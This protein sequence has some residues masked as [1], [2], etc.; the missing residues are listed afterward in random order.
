MNTDQSLT[1][2][3]SFIYHHLTE[4]FTL[5]DLAQASHMSLSTLRRLFLKTFAKSPASII[6]Q[7]RMELAFKSIQDHQNSILEIAISAGYDDHAAF[8]RAFKS[9]FGYT[10]S[11]AK[12]KVNIIQELENIELEEPDII[13]LNP[14]SLSGITTKGPYHLCAAEA[15]RS[16]A[17]HIDI[18]QTLTPFVG[19]SLDNP[20]EEETPYHQCRFT[21]LIPE[22][23]PGLEHTIIEQGKYARFYFKGLVHN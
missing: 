17:T 8:S 19:I 11:I 2:A 5:E 20:H 18:T 7:L 12:Q 10:P 16:L 6:R 21:A 1:N 23:I 14:L 9:T 15:W 13:T 22:D 3:L 4:P